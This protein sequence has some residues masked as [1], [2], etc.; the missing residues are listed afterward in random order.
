MPVDNAENTLYTGSNEA[1]Q[2]YWETHPFSNLQ[3]VRMWQADQLDKTLSGTNIPIDAMTAST[4]YNS[5]TPNAPST[6][7]V[8]AR[9]D[10]SPWQRE[11][12]QE[13]SPSRDTGRSSQQNEPIAAVP[14]TNEE[15]ESGHL[16][17]GDMQMSTEAHSPWH[18]DSANVASI[19]QTLASSRAP[20]LASSG[21][22][23]SASTQ[24]QSHNVNMYTSQ[25]P[26]LLEP[27]PEPDY[28]H[29][30]L[31]EHAQRSHPVAQGLEQS[32]QPPQVDDGEPIEDLFW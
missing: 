1:N 26:M 7:P 29:N 4:A 32:I 13:T 8:F 15:T 2:K 31:V 5:L 19:L 27:L 10:E 23:A 30:V 18:T 11:E 17:E 28:S 22:E 16:W 21:A 12:G 25:D 24:P 20:P 6:F 3:E 14:Q 9:A